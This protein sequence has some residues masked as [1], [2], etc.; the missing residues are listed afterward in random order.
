[1]D[2]GQDLEVLW[3][4]AAL[5]GEDALEA[6]LERGRLEDGELASLIARRKVFPCYFGSA[7]RLG[8]GDA[9]LGP[10]P[11]KVRLRPVTAHTVPASTRSAVRNLAP[12]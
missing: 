4:A 6:Y 1:M 3:E 8:G 9:L 2:F 5:C 10:W 7:L 11:G 12:E